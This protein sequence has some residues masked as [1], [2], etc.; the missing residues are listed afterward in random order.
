MTDSTDD[1][2]IR[3]FIK[4]V[5]RLTYAFSTKWDNHRAAFGLFF[6]HYNYFRKHG[7]LKGLTPAIAHGPTTEVWTVRKMLEMVLE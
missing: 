4:R 5:N 7:S 3:L 6:T 1:E 2:L